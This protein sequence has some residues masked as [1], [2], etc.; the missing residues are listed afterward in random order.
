MSKQIAIKGETFL[1]EK[2][3]LPKQNTWKALARL[4]HE[5]D[6]VLVKD[7]QQAKILKA[8]MHAHYRSTGQAVKTMARQW[9]PGNQY[10]VWRLSEGGTTNG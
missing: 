4:M 7:A 8:A 2:D 9:G 1:I 10:R 5:G 6:S 3:I